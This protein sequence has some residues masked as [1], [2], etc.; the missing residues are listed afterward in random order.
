MRKGIILAGGAGARLHA[1]T[2]AVINQFLP[3]NHAGV[4]QFQRKRHLEAV[5]RTS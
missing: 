1:A 5:W 2:Y 3:V 4:K